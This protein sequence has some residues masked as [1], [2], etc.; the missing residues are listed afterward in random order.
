M[1]L[2]AILLLIFV[3]YIASA[4][5]SPGPLFMWSNQKTFTPHK[6]NIMKSK[7]DSIENILENILSISND[8]GD[9]K[10]YLHKEVPLPEVI[11]IFLK[12]TL[13]STKFSQSADVYNG[14]KDGSFTNLQNL[15]QNSKSS[16][17]VHYSHLKES[18]ATDVLSKLTSKING[19]YPNAKIIL[20]S[21]HKSDVSHFPSTHK[22]IPLSTLEEYLASGEGKE[23]VL[24]GTPDILIVYL[25]KDESKEMISKEDNIIGIV[26]N[27]VS[28]ETQHNSIGI[29][30][31]DV[32]E[33][34]DF[35]ISNNALKETV[36]QYNNKQQIRRASND[37]DYAGTYFPPQ[38][39]QAI[40]VVIVLLIA[41][42]I[43]L[44]ATSSLQ[45]PPKLLDEKM[46]K[47]KN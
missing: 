5:K 43:G 23:Y 1:K 22:W 30:S 29:F 37:S 26:S 39:W 2:L 41:F 40:F 18:F 13:T 10:K 42:F 7:S 15:V 19:N 33:E 12:P 11:T 8:E 36:F 44:S 3:V 45:I 31:S 17:S 21:V 9:L 46:A 20:S 14:G 27:I 28:V 6:V 25:S 35:S 4:T 24:N 32:P 16:L 47:K 34:H 38:M